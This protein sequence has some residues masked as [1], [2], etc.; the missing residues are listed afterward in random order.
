MALLWLIFYLD[1]IASQLFHE[2]TQYIIIHQYSD[3]CPWLLS[4]NPAFVELVQSSNGN[5][6]RTNHPG[7]QS[8]NP[9]RTKTTKRRARKNVSVI[10]AHFTQTGIS[11][12]QEETFIFANMVFCI[13][14]FTWMFACGW[15]CFFFSR[16]YFIQIHQLKPCTCNFVLE[17][18]IYFPNMFSGISVAI[19]SLTLLDFINAPQALSMDYFHKV[20]VENG[21]SFSMNL[22]DSVTHCIA[23]DKK[24]L[25][26]FFILRRTADMVLWLRF[27]FL[28]WKGLDI[29]QQFSMEMSFTI[30]GS[31]IVASKSA[32]Y[33]CNQS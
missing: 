4:T 23:A 26:L 21:G 25:P 27:W 20:V 7:S 14:P 11:N 13:L 16:I 3:T 1:N 19:T 12:I 32:F 29:R 5:T 31:W 18:L 17:W 22:N 2:C 6:W 10:S 8:Q 28:I 15:N 24:G 30:L 33:I 9:K